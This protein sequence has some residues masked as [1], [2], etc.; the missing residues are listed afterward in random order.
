MHDPADRFLSSYDFDLPEDRIAQRPVEP[1]HDARLLVVEPGEGARHRRVW[2]L[3][4]ELRRGDLLVVNNTRVLHARL[5]ARRSSGGAVELLV[6]EPLGSGLW[7]CLARPA[8]R[9]RDGEW[10]SLQA[11]GQ[12]HLAVQVVGGLEERGAR[13]IRFPPEIGRA[14]V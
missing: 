9:L 10:L 12:P 4:E 13:R 2:D 1:R 11:H 7:L 5:A 3:Q 14:H 6:V 8:R